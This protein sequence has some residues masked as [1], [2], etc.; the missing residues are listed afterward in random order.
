M[1]KN[2]EQERKN[3]GWDDYIRL[4]AVTIEEKGGQTHALGIW[5]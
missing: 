5:K 3:I 2:V 1:A 4:A